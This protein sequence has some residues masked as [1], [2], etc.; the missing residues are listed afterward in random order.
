MHPPHLLTI[1]IFLPLAGGAALLVLGG[2]DRTWI[3]WCALVFALAV[4][5]SSLRL[6]RGV[7]ASTAAY[8]SE[9]LRAWIPSPPIHYHVGV[10]G[11]SLFLVL[12]TTFLTPVA[13]LSSWKSI[14]NRVQ[15]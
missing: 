7:T 3:R 9:E 13:M 11:I 1:L 2:E 12:L 14:Q 15:G 6:V 5:S 4:V 8:Q 10:D